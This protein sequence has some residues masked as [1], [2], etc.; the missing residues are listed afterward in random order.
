MSWPIIACILGSANIVVAIFIKAGFPSKPPRS[1]P[2]NAP[3]GKAATPGPGLP[4]KKK[5]KLHSYLKVPGKYRVA[6]ANFP[7]F[8]LNPIKNTENLPR[9]PCNLWKQIV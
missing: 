5:N 1:N 7:R 3:G 9:Q 2:P 8:L 6:E 4:P